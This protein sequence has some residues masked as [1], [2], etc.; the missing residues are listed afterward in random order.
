MNHISRPEFLYHYTSIDTLAM[1]LKTKTIRFSRLDHV[2]DL[3]ESKTADGEQLGK[4][5]FVSCWTNDDRENIPLWK[6]YAGLNGVRIK[7]KVNLFKEYHLDGEEGSKIKF[8][9]YGL[10][11]N[12]RLPYRGPVKPEELLQN[13]YAIMPDFSKREFPR[14][15][16]YTEDEEYLTPKILLKEN[17]TET[18]KLDVFGKYK[19][20]YWK[21]QSEW[22]YILYLIPFD[23]LK[24]NK[25]AKINDVIP[26]LT[27]NYPFDKQFHCLDISDS[28]LKSMEI[29]LGPHCTE[30]DKIIVKALKDKYAPQSTLLDSALK[31]KI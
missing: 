9:K 22:R 15:V 25:D 27:I 13:G 1:I 11:M 19:S 10:Y 8:E 24:I 14:E 16:K 7:M 2:D 30:G 5:Y 23:K 6:M 20:L 17:G 26:S 12:L 29:T 28:A 3:T 21:F 4:H 18:I 31:N